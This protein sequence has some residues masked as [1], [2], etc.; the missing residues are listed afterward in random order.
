MSSELLQELDSLTLQM[1]IQI[2]TPTNFSIDR[3]LQGRSLS[4]G[5]GGERCRTNFDR[6]SLSI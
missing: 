6:L 4:F 5:L 1:P 3:I 2:G